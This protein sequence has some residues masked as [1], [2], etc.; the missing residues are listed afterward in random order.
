MY[1]INWLNTKNQRFLLIA[2]V[3]V[4]FFALTFKRNACGSRKIAFPGKRKGDDESLTIKLK[5]PK[6]NDLKLPTKSNEFEW[7][8]TTF[9]LFLEKTHFSSY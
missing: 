8:L 6:S 5:I 4:Q 2:V 3:F 7:S 1:R 9:S